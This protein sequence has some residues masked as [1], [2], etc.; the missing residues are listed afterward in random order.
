MEV[1]QELYDN[2][3]YIDYTKYMELH[4]ISGYN[5]ETIYGEDGVTVLKSAGLQIEEKIV[6]IDWHLYDFII[7]IN[8]QLRRAFARHISKRK[9][10][11]DSLVLQNMQ[12]GILEY[13]PWLIDYMSYTGLKQLK[14]FQIIGDNLITN[15]CGYAKK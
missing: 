13:Y 5:D 10:E 1:N 9:Q 11:I 6:E 8:G 4:I 14:E 2:N 3:G 7:K 12:D 15:P